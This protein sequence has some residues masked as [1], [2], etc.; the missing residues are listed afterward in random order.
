MVYG[1][2]HYNKAQ[3]EAF[4]GQLAKHMTAL[5]DQSAAMK[6]AVDHF[7]QVWQGKGVESFK[8]AHLQ[9]NKEFDGV[10]AIVAELKHNTLAAVEAMFGADAKVATMFYS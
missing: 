6:K 1:K 9:W 5:E 2:I 8:D 7:E 4:C 3:I 10:K